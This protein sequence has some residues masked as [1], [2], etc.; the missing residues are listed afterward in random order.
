MAVIYLL[1]TVVTADS[2]AYIATGA[3]TKVECVND[4]FGSPNG[5]RYL[6]TVTNG[7]EIRFRFQDMVDAVSINSVTLHVVHWFSGTITTQTLQ[8]V[9]NSNAVDTYTAAR[10][11][12]PSFVDFTDVFTLNGAGQPWSVADLRG[13]LTTAGVRFFTPGDGDFITSILLAVDYVAR[14]QGT[15]AARQVASQ[16]LR[17]LRK[18]TPLVTFSAPLSV[19]HADLLSLLPVTH[20]LGPE[21]NGLGWGDTPWKRRPTI[22]LGKTL[23][24]NAYTIRA[25]ALDVRQSI[26]LYRLWRSMRTKDP[27]GPAA[28]GIAQADVGA[29]A[30]YVRAGKAWILNADGR[31]LSVAA[32]VEKFQ[33]EGEAL[34]AARTNTLQ[35]SSFKNGTTGWTLTVGSGAIAVDALDLLFDAAETPNSLKFTA[36][37]PN[38]TGPLAQSTNTASYAANAPIVVSVD[39]SGDVGTV[40]SVK[41]L[42]NFDG[43]GWD[44]T[45]GTF[46]G[47]PFN[48]LPTC[49]GTKQRWESKVINVG[50]NATTIRIDLKMPDG[51]TAARVNH[52]YHVQ[53][54]QG[55][56]A[57]SRILTET[58][59]VTRA[60]DDL[61]LTTNFAPHIWPVE[62]GTALFDFVPDWSTAKLGATSGENFDF[63]LC[64]YSAS[65]SELVS[66]N[67]NAGEFRFT[68]MINGVNSRAKKAVTVT[69]GTKVS[70]AARWTSSEG[71]L[72]LAPY[73][74][75]VFVNGVK[76]TDDTGGGKPVPSAA[77]VL[78]IGGKA[79]T[80]NAGGQM[81]NLLIT[82]LVLTDEEIA[83]LSTA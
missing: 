37:S 41:I 6:I 25:K 32:D 51:G 58:A 23:D 47:T 55:F 1:P 4:P 49:D 57:S 70:I 53:V 52:V 66:F 40:F 31:V 16:V 64:D 81:S 48:S 10:A 80:V 20:P 34:E 78:Q 26:L 3:P 9:I 8:S 13:G 33:R 30:T 71:E 76:G 5:D 19:G 28:N 67:G 14:A 68:R 38:T 11:P 2:A 43:V 72:G 15:G 82:D 65:Q 60:V 42:R 36:G 73:T 75:S 61:R 46:S 18:P 69:R 77:V 35:R 12:T 17:V 74:N 29:V 27:A 54:E 83:D 59:S 79:G 24:P 22:L 63:L 44:D 7:S 21:V 62:R 45:S 39:Y 50:A 56:Y